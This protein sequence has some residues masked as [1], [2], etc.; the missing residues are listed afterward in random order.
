MGVFY[1]FFGIVKIVGVFGVLDCFV[2]YCFLLDCGGFV[3][4]DQKYLVIGFW[5]FGDN[6]VQQ[7]LY[8]GVVGFGDC[9]GF[10]LVVQFV[11]EYIDGVGEE[12]YEQCQFG[13][14]VYL[15]MQVDL[16]FYG[17]DVYQVFL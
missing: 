1:G 15:G 17:I 14:N 16:L 2:V 10:L 13:N 4:G 11:V 6:C 12:C 9:L 7:C 5:V 3:V 8:V